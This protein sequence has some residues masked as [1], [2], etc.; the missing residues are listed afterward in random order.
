MMEEIIKV[1]RIVFCLEP[2]PRIPRLLFINIGHSD[3]FNLFFQGLDRQEMG[4]GNP[5][6]PDHSDSQFSFLGHFLFNSPLLSFFN[7]SGG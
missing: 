6:T 1:V 3:K 4:L 5:A 2:F 7:R